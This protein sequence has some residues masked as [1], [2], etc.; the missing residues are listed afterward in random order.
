MTKN[1]SHTFH[2]KARPDAI[3]KALTDGGEISR[4]WTAESRLADGKG[5]FDWSVLGFSV[6][7]EI[8]K[9]DEDGVIWHCTKSNMQNTSAWEDT[10][11]VFAFFPDQHGTRV[12]FEHRDYRDS[13]CYGTCFAGWHYVLGKSLKALLETGTGMP[14]CP[15]TQAEMLKASQQ[16]AA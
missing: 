10:R 4:W 7:L 16:Q 5:R 13:P 9:A 15:R 8:E 3:L 6:E 12:E 1:I 14:L 11:M 2:F